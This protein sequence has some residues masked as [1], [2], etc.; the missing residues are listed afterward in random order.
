MEHK[1]LLNYPEDKGK[2]SDDI[3]DFFYSEILFTRAN[4][5]HELWLVS[6]WITDSSFNLSERG[7]FTDIWSNYSNSSIKF[8]QIL[9]NF[10]DYNS[11]INIVTR[12][13]HRL[14]SPYSFFDYQ[15]YYNIFE[16]IDSNFEN[17]KKEQQKIPEMSTNVRKT[18]KE[19]HENTEK[20]RQGI[21][22]LKPF[23]NSFVQ[24][25]GSHS[26]ELEL[27]RDIKEYR[28]ENVDI[29][30]NDKLHAKILL[31]RFGAY[32]GSSNIT[33][34]PILQPPSLFLSQ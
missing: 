21:D 19:I 14:I 6:P 30:Y 15:N 33:Y 23:M 27:L 26:A 22:Q 12:S 7:E 28:E 25:I 1:F 20:L 29:Y 5:D 4:D 24:S 9:K 10:L 2:I 16:E 34:S 32:I 17:L 11:R 31:G 18:L 8:T 3:L 13:P